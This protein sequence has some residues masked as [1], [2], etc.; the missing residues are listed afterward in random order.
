MKL[1]NF[2]LCEMVRPDLGNKFSLLGVFGGDLFVP[3][4]PV[5]IQF[6][7]YFEV[8]KVAP[9]HRSLLVKVD[10][11]GVDLKVEG[12]FDVSADPEV[13]ALPIPNLNLTIEKPGDIIVSIS[14][15]GQEIASD[16]RVIGLAAD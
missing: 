6:S 4:F 2:I 11:P 16:R 13:A 1:R 8:E 9:G 14:I 10:A 5:Q 7:A 3:S 15:D 12:G